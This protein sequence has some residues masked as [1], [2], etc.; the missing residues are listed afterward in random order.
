M[1]K[2]TS[3]VCASL[4]ILSIGFLFQVGGID[5]QQFTTQLAV[6]LCLL[7]PVVLF[8]GF[9]PDIIRRIRK[10]V[11]PTTEDNRKLTEIY[12]PI[13]AMIVAINNT[14]PREEALRMTLGYFVNVKVFRQK[15]LPIDFDKISAIFNQHVHELGDNNLKMWLELEKDIKEQGGFFLRKDRQ[16]WFDELEAEYNRLTKRLG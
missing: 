16:E 4:L 7:I 2:I 14:I 3:I 8:W 12:S 9:K 13:H 10:P 6:G 5:I 1:R 11:G 15:M